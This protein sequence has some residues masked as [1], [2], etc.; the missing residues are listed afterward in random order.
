MRSARSSASS[1]DS[2]CRIGGFCC[3][4][5]AWMCPVVCSTKPPRFYAPFTAY[6][7]DP[8]FRTVASTTE[9]E[10]HRMLSLQFGEPPAFRSVV[11]KLI[12]GEH[13]SWK[14]V[15]SDTK[16]SAGLMRSAASG[17]KD[18]LPSQPR[19]AAPISPGRRIVEPTAAGVGGASYPRRHRASAARRRAASGSPRVR[20]IGGADIRVKAERNRGPGPEAPGYAPRSPMRSIGGWYFPDYRVFRTRRQYIRTR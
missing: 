17:R 19:R 16:P 5:C 10:N 18:L 2:S 20:C 1:S 6:F 9:H 13:R 14:D 12:I 4:S 11:G 8:V 15:R 3:V 7:H